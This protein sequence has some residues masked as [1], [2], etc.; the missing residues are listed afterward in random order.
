MKPLQEFS[1]IF[2]YRELLRNLIERDIKKRYKR[3][4]LGFLWVMLDPLLMMLIF[5]IVFAGLFGKAVGNY[6]AYVI[7]GIIMWQ[8]FAQ[9]TKVSSTAFIHNR[10]LIS[11]IH[12]PTAIFP[13]AIVGSSVVHFIFSLIPLFIIILF[14]GTIPSY[15]LPLLPVTIALIVIF[16]MGISLTISTLTVFFHD[17]LYIY[18]VIL[19]GWMYLSAIFYPVA[20]LPQKFQTLISLNPLYHYISL[21]RAC[22]YDTTLPVM[23]HL[24]FGT[25]FAVISFAMGWTIYHQNRDKIIFYI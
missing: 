21:F 20:I 10:N 7:T 13:I 18:D 17:V 22:I 6:A 19:I 25:A 23:E 2:R 4:A 16:S 5:Y 12:L 9:G 15:Y 14:S 24:M 8:L 3:S 1:E 11:K